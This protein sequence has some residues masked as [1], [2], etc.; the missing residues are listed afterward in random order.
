MKTKLVLTCLLPLLVSAC[1]T[2]Q[3][4]WLTEPCPHYKRIQ[5]AAFDGAIKPEP[6]QYGTVKPYQLPE[7]IG[8]PYD[9]IGF[10]S[11]QGSANE[12]AAIL[13]AMLY[14]AADMGA[15]GIILNAPGVANETLKSPDSINIQIRT[16]GWGLLSGNPN[17]DQRI[18]RAYAFRLK[19]VSTATGPKP[20]SFTAH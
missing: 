19:P 3:V 17:S 16:R 18:F 10:M 9:Q 20:P 1:A 4:T 14:R 15:D 13:N 12:E 7:D 11:C 6:R 2:H 5:V 8:Q